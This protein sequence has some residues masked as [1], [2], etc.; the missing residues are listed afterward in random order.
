MSA[1]AAIA[2]FAVHAPGT[3]TDH[4][5]MSALLAEEACPPAQA[6]TL[7]GRK[8]LLGKDSA[9]R[10]ALCAVHR[11]L[12]LPPGKPTAAVP[13]AS[14]TA[15]VVSS[16]LGNAGTVCDAAA[17]VSA[18]ERRDISPLDIPNASSNVIASTIAI[19][20]GCTGPNLTVCGGRTSGIDALGLAVR[21]LAAGRADRAVVVGVEPGDGP[22]GLAGTSAAAACVVLDRAP[23]KV[24]VRTAR[25]HDGPTPSLVTESAALRLGPDD[26]TAVFGETY[27]ATGVL[28]AA[29]AAA[30]LAGGRAPG[31]V[32]TCGDAED[33]YASVRLDA[34]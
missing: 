6:H 1:R 14:S 27:G 21:L 9:T 15:V 2:G 28:Q 8:G 20:F 12:G 19:R 16:N 10:L 17:K 18:G 3:T 33:G 22:V 13:G 23:G 5:L 29:V 11:A 4:E 26:L 32:L 34:A 7:L 25:Q 31:A 30:W 24:V